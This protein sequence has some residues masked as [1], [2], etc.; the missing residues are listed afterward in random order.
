M[1]EEAPSDGLTSFMGSMRIGW[2]FG[3]APIRWPGRKNGTCNY[4]TY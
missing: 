2:L 1:F 3:F 4:S